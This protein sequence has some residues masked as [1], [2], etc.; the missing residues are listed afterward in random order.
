MQINEKLKTVRKKQRLSQ[1]AMADLLGIKQSYYSAIERGEKEPSKTVLQALENSSILAKRDIFD[2]TSNKRNLEGILM[3]KS[4]VKNDLLINNK[5][6]HNIYGDLEVIDYLTHS[7]NKLLP[8]IILDGM[9]NL[10]SYSNHTLKDDL[11]NEDYK[12]Y[13]SNISNQLKLLS[14]QK[15]Q[16][17]K[18]ARQLE[19]F[20]SAMKVFDAD[21]VLPNF[22]LSRKPV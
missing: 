4:R 15:T 9:D 14:K 13:Y 18:F 19:D 22:H 1:A 17:E 10:T 8:T 6:L 3:N 5:N 16:I 2:A 20:L 21:D 12:I 11:L 7:L